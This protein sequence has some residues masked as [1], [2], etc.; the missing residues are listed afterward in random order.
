MKYAAACLPSTFY[1][2]GQIVEL[3]GEKNKFGKPI[4]FSVFLHEIRGDPS[5]CA[6]NLVPGLVPLG[7]C[8]ERAER[9]VA[10]LFLA[11]CGAGFGG[12]PGASLAGVWLDH[13]L[14]SKG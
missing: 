10:G 14:G 9:I 1:T 8:D 12:G 11:L 4:Q 6:D 3:G 7:G 5:R 13:C 2:S